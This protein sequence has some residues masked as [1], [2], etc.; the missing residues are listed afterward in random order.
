MSVVV[1]VVPGDTGA[2]LDDTLTPNFSGFCTW[3][4]FPSAPSL[5]A[6]GTPDVCVRISSAYLL[7]LAHSAWRKSLIALLFVSLFTPSG[8]GFALRLSNP[9]SH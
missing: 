1:V 7:W 3:L 9:S 4:S 5:P 8:I 2:Y 6:T